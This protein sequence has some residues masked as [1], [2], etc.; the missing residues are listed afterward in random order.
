MRRIVL[1]LLL[2]WPFGALA[3]Q[4]TVPYP[5][6]P[7][8]YQQITSLSAATKLTVPL[9][10]KTAVITCESANVRFR[11]DNVAP[12]ASVGF[13]VPVGAN[14]YYRGVLSQ[15]QIIQTASSA[16]CNILYYP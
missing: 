2:L 11:D 14:V 7:L 10:A 3:Q 5:T 13:L 9:T 8:G 1:T 16:T 6:T 15:I 12:T 4:Q